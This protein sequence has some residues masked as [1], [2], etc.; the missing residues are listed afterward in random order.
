M[1]ILSPTIKL[2]FQ[3]QKQHE[4]KKLVG[5]SIA[6]ALISLSV[7]FALATQYFSFNF[8]PPYKAEPWA[9]LYLLVLPSTYFLFRKGSKPDAT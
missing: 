1:L 8:S 6:V 2:V 7:L 4:F 9:S 5:P 3:A